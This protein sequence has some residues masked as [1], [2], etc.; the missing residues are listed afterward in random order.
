MNRIL[1]ILIL[2]MGCNENN[3]HIYYETFL[4]EKLSLKD[5]SNPYVKYIEKNPFQDK[6]LFPLI[7]SILDKDNLLS[8]YP[9]SSIYYHLY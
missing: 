9:D 6:Y 2:F 5:R 1:V 3:N 4:M 7:K 8:S